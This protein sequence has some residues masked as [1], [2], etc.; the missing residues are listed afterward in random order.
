MN[1]IERFMILCL[2]I[3]SYLRWTFEPTKESRVLV[4]VSSSQHT[5]S[6]THTHTHTHTKGLAAK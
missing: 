3:K 2:Q 4:F 1:E 5:N 6:H